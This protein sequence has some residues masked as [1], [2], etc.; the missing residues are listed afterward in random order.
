[1]EED[2]GVNMTQAF[3][4]GS[5]YQR[6]I[7]SANMYFFDHHVQVFGQEVVHRLTLSEF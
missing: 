4:S 6:P 3:L 5:F 7:R 2:L 1:M